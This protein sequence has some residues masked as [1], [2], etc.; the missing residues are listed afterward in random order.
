MLV[1]DVFHRCHP[2]AIWN[3]GGEKMG[4]PSVYQSSLQTK[5]AFEWGV[6]ISLSL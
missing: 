5:R 3:S 1:F 4:D 6:S 2:I